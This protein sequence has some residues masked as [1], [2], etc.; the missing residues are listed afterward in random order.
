MFEF[1]GHKFDKDIVGVRD[2]SIKKL[3]ENLNVL[4]TLYK[5]KSLTDEQLY[6]KLNYKIVGCTID[7]K[8]YGW[9]NFF[10]Q[11][12][13][14]NLLYTID[15][16]LEKMCSKH[17]LDYTKLK[18]F[19]RAIYEMK[20]PQSKYMKVKNSCNFNIKPYELKLELQSD[21]EFYQQERKNIIFL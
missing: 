19:S 16:F 8:K 3:Y 2:R 17:W 20:N 14:Y 15:K 11:L 9:L 13:D 4:F 6:M 18:K 1:L 5:F 12:N 10:N 21:V 7:G